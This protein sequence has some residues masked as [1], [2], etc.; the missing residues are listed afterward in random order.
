MGGPAYSQSAYETK[1]EKDA[2]L[3][4]LMPG[5]FGRSTHGGFS[6]AE[7]LGE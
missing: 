4:N 2:Q 7:R 6:F 3:Q 1:H 5:T